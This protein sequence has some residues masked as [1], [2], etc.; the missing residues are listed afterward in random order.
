[1]FFSDRIKMS[2]VAMFVGAALNHP[3]PPCN[4]GE[5]ISTIH[6][7]QYK[8]KFD[9]VRIYCKLAHPD[10][11][12][13]AWAS[14]AGSGEPPDEF[15]RVRFFLDAQHYRACYFAMFQLLNDEELIAS[16]KGPADYSEALCK[17]PEELDRVLNFDFERSKLYPQ[18]IQSYY[19]KWGVS[20]FES[21]RNLIR[22]VSGFK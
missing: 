5:I 15:K 4:G 10:L 9:D 1:M 2:N 6:V 3:M 22:K 17:T 12:K 8:T 7:D 14:Q 18:Y 19:M 21:L 13:A 16:L 11:V 20:D